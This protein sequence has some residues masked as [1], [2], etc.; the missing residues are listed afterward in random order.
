MLRVE[1]IVK[2]NHFPEKNLL[3]VQRSFQRTAILLPVL[4]EN[5]AGS[6]L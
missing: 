1:V 3:L 6:A 4:T 2:V 5:Q